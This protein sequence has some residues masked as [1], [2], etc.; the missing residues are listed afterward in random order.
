MSAETT[1]KH[2]LK[3]L[4]VRVTALELQNRRFLT[5]LNKML[6]WVQAVQKLLD[7]ARDAARSQQEQ[8]IRAAAVPQM[9]IAPNDAAGPDLEKRDTP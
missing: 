5:E 9:Q 7:D 8:Q 4:Q 6:E 3:L 2:R 1:K